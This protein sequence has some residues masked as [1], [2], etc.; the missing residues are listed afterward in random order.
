MDIQIPLMKT[1]TVRPWV[2][3][4][5]N[6]LYEW[7]CRSQT[8]MSW[9]IITDTCPSKTLPPRWLPASRTIYKPYAIQ[10][11]AYVRPYGACNPRGM[12]LTNPRNM[13]AR[14]G[15]LTNPPCNPKMHLTKSKKHVIASHL[16]ETPRTSLDAPLAQHIRIEL[17]GLA[18]KILTKATYHR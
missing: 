12:H 14:Q 8:G 9:W 5:H 6:Y 15:R 13:L 16:H 1:W 10:E 18:R 11:N 7:T 17:V 3:F 2:I 4:I